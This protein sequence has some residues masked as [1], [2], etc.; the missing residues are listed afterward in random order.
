MLVFMP[1]G[2]VKYFGKEDFLR[3]QAS[4]PATVA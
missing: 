1:D 2:R 3:L 4:A